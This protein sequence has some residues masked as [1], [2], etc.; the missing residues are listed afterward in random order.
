[1][2]SFL[3]LISAKNLLKMVKLSRSFDED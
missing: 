2:L 3:I 1:M